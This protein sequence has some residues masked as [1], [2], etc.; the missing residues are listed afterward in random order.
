MKPGHI[1]FGGFMGTKGKERIGAE[2]R[3][4]LK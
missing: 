4:A 1:G 3:G 2:N